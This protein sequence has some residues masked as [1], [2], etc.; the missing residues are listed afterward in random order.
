MAPASPP[1]EPARIRAEF[2]AL[3]QEVHGRPLVYLDSAATALKPRAVLAAIQEVYTRDCANIHRGVHLLSQRATEAYEAAR[4]RVRRFLGAASDREVIFL[5]STTEA[6]NLVAQAWGR[7]RLGPGDEILITGLE[8]HSNIV[9]WQILAEQTGARLRVAPLDEAG[10][11][12]REAWRRLL[13]PRV[14]LAALAHV[15]NALGTVNPVAEM[16][17]E[18]HAAGALVLVDGA[19]AVPHLPVDVQALGCDFYAFSGHKLYGPTGVG[20]LWAREAILA[21]MPPWQGGGDMIRSVTF[22]RTEYN[23]LPWRFEAGTP[24]IAGA[25]G[26][27]AAIDWLEAL[28]REAVAAHET[29]LLE[30]GEAILAGVPG[31]RFIGRARERAAVLSFVLEGIHPHDVGTVLDQEGVA[32][33]TGHHCAQPVMD[34]YGVPATVRASLGVY[35]TLADLEAL[36]TALGRVREIFAA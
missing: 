11:V 7:P 23:D 13:G 18:A 15:S 17:R 19:Q 22:E 27:G 21:G 16:V 3:D 8:H 9:P 25:I 33:R 4:G 24:H 30:A 1:L 2:P 10:D 20:V 36:A 6:I 14:R 26:L 5:R 32:V 34:R 12:D 29:A 31:L 28:D 35:N